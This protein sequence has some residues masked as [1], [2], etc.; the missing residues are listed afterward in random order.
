MFISSR[1]AIE[2]K[3]IIGVRDESQIQPNAIDITADRMFKL[4]D[5]NAFTFNSAGKTHRNRTE[6]VNPD[7]WKLEPGVYDIVSD[8]YV[9]MRQGVAGYL[10]TRSTLNRNS[11]FIQSGLYDS[12]YK[13][14]VQCMLYNLFGITV[15]EPGISVA[16]F[17]FVDA[18]SNHNYKGGYNT[19]KGQLPDY[20]ESSD[21]LHVDKKPWMRKP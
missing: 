16:Q 8:C 6:L 12:G 7:V 14:P 9:E 10:I 11:V 1:K 19:E 15:L 18:P 17:V 21:P 20:I 13:G 4:N 2:E 3:W 5:H